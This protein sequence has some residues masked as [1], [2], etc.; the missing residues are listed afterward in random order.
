MARGRMISK[1]ISTSRKFSRLPSDQARMLYLMLLPHTNDFG[2]IEGEEFWIKYNV[3]P[4]L[5]HWTE[6]LIA[7]TLK[8]IEGVGLAFWYQNNGK[9]YI[10]ITNFDEH[11]DLHKRTKSRLPD[12]SGK[13]REV[14][15]KS[16]NATEIPPRREEKLREVEVKKNLKEDLK[17]F[18]F[19]SSDVE[20]SNLL[21][22]RIIQN[23]P[24][25]KITQGQ[26]N[27]WA[28]CCRKM[29]T[30]DKRTEAEIR[31]VLEWSQQD[32]FWWRNILSMKKLRKQFDQLSVKMNA[33]HST[34]EDREYQK[35]LELARKRNEENQ[36]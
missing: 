28:D 31:E 23:N 27:E 33:S 24:K 18:L 6:E 25:A 20:L 8:E 22:D 12:H 4:T 17:D 3:V 9:K 11:Q 26:L 36:K 13:F 29:R 19:S 30:I 5:E 7:N 10:E 14:P 2:I 21:K 35:F 15:G 32:D 16:C 1:S 34:G